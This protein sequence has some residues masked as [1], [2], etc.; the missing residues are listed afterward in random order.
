[1][2]W[3]YL[4][5]FTTRTTKNNSCFLFGKLGGRSK[6]NFYFSSG[7]YPLHWHPASAPL[8]SGCHDF[9][10]CYL[11]LAAAPHYKKA[12]HHGMY[13]PKGLF[14]SIGLDDCR[15]YDTV[16]HSLRNLPCTTNAVIYKRNNTLFT[17]HGLP[18]CK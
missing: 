14:Q 7:C 2:V 5:P 17:G 18:Y 1:M 13:H 4:T 16:Y 10:H 8:G 9:I 11:L 6:T 15:L 3:G 12:G